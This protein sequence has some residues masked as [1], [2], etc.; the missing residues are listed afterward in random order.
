MPSGSHMTRDFKVN[1]EQDAHH[2]AL[3]R[4]GIAQGRKVL[5]DNPAPDTFAGRKVCARASIEPPAVRRRAVKEIRRANRKLEQEHLSR[6][7]A[8]IAKA[9]RLVSEQKAQIEKLR[10]DGHDT[11]LACQTL[12]VFETNLQTMREH[13]EAIIRAIEDMD[14]SL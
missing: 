8:H 11:A 5:E 12:H 14:D 13:R 7:D 6:A 3:A 1:Q 9:Q 2:L 10:G 4:A